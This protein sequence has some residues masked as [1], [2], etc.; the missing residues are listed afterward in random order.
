VLLRQIPLGESSFGMIGR[1]LLQ[2]AQE[3][4]PLDEATIAG[5]HYLELTA[6]Q[7]Q[8]AFARHLRPDAFV[9]AT[10]GPAPKG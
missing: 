1:Q 8:Q 6:A 2:L 10:K 5:R 4:K 7:V 9:T 3:G